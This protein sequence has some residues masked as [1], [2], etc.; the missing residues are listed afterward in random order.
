L[1]VLADARDVEILWG[2]LLQQLIGGNTSARLCFLDSKK[3]AT[4]TLLA[5]SPILTFRTPQG[6]FSGPDCGNV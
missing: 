3:A 5:A 2:V 4:L 6:L 1:L